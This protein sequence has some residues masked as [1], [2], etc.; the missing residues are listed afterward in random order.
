[1]QRGEVDTLFLKFNSRVWIFK[2]PKDLETLWE[3]MDS[4]KEEE[5][6]YWVEIWPSCKLLAEYIWKN[7]EKLRGKI[8]VDVGCGLG[9]ATLVAKKIGAKIIGLDY[10][11][12]ALTFAKQNALINRVDNPFFL[13]MNWFYPAL[14]EKSLD[15]I[16]AS[17]IFYEKRF[18]HNLD[19]F[20]KTCLKD[21]GFI[22]L[23]VPD[24]EVSKE[25]IAFLRNAGWKL[26]LL[27]EEKI[28][29]AL[30]SPL[31]SLWELSKEANYG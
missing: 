26:E 21:S 29:F 6:P 5:I 19:S 11:Y 4:L 17:D 24:R 13:Q 12:E 20:F 3:E 31:V 25:G 2:R 10:I 1:M 16:L 18:F 27:K 15:F 30:Q 28:N 22:W 8:G 9:A 23:S 14:K 7:P